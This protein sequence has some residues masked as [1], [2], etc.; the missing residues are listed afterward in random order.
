[1]NSQAAI[2]HFN[3]SR[4][5][6]TQGR[7]AKAATCAA[8][9]LAAEPEA[10]LWLFLSG[11][12]E[13]AQFWMSNG[14]RKA[15]LGTVKRIFE[16]PGPY[17]FEALKPEQLE[18]VPGA[19][20]QQLQTAAL[21]HLSNAGQLANGLDAQL[22]E[23][24]T[25]TAR[26][27]DH[28]WATQPSA[29]PALVSEQICLLDISI[30]QAMGVAWVNDL[31]PCPIVMLK[32]HLA[33]LSSAKPSTVARKLR[34]ALI[35]TQRFHE[36][37]MPA[38]LGN[39]ADPILDQLWRR[40]SESDIVLITADPTQVR[41]ADGL[42][43]LSDK[44][45]DPQR[46]PIKRQL[47][48]VKPA[49]KLPDW[50]I[51]KNVGGVSPL[52]AQPRANGKSPLFSTRVNEQVFADLRPIEV[53]AANTGDVLST[54][55]KG[56]RRLV[57]EQLGFGGEGGVYLTDCGDICKVYQPGKP[58]VATLKKL[59]LMVKRPIGHPLIC[60]P[61]ELVHKDDVFVGYLMPRA[62]G[63]I[64]RSVTNPEKILNAFPNWTRQDLAKLALKVCEVVEYVHGN[65]ILVGDLS[66]TNIMVDELGQPWFIDTDSYQLGSF[67]SPVGRRPFIHPDLLG[68]DL[69]QMFRLIEHEWFALA[70]L[71]F[72][73]LF[74][75][76][77]PYAGAG[78]DN[79][80]D[81][82]RDR[83]FPYRID[84]VGDP[85]LDQRE[86][87]LGPPWT[88]AWSNLSRDLRLAFSAVFRQGKEK[89]A[90]LD[91]GE[92]PYDAT[93]WRK[94]LQTY[95]RDLDGN[96][97][98]SKEL[99]P[100]R[101][102]LTKPK[103]D[104]ERRICERCEKPF[105]APKAASSEQVSKIKQKR[106]RYCLTCLNTLLS[107]PCEITRSNGKPCKGKFLVRFRDLDKHKRKIC[108]FHQTN[109]P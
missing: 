103:A 8:K 53:A 9:A 2:R 59:Q 105:N 28:G 86:S 47:R 61:T 19:M 81:D 72:M 40:G 38:D 42:R 69:K 25:L 6:L 45:P 39:D 10:P 26:E 3:E 98:L 5:M 82:H 50:P 14:D 84:K 22:I 99:F 80:E 18:P 54:S 33:R 43:M 66:D 37:A 51:P 108:T 102:P 106:S 75:G 87:Q 94:A 67:P 7:L 104:E 76:R 74:P 91:P 21:D 83:V 77:P 57:S 55:A 63:Q 48:L 32:P 65:N 109:P 92:G 49:A 96:S 34:D 12:I 97:R 71:V 23:R 36:A 11:S 93:F 58:T 78:A 4:Y 30:E 20:A 70:T 24:I 31:P 88:L 27:L 56:Y 100:T 90:A 44:L 17:E 89:V 16:F 62:H 41:A 73:I 68:A 107:F 35:A 52:G 1:M 15:A 46:A 101:Y 29:P 85:R 60:W 95:I 79:Q 13:A 64:M